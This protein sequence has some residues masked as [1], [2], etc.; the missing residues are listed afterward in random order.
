MILDKIQQSDLKSIASK[1]NWISAHSR[2]DTSYHVCQR[3]N[4]AKK[5]TAK[6][7]V[8][9]NKA[10]KKIKSEEVQLIFP[11]L[12]NENKLEFLCFAD[13][14]LGNL[15]GHASQGGYIT[16]LSSASQVPPDITKARACQPHG[17]RI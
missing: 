10:L 7:Q 9:A 12:G 1:L 5:A 11:N 16:S 2:P 14:S 15:K 6:D 8:N 13:A 4:S 3:N 17:L